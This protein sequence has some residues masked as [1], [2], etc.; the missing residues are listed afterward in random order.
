MAKFFESML[1]ALQFSV[2][3]LEE[4]LAKLE[5]HQICIELKKLIT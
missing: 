3:L 4:H 1:L 5:F 2:T